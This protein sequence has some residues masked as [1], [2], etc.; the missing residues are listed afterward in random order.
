MPVFI[1]ADSL[2]TNLPT[3]SIK[4]VQIP[5]GSKPDDVMEKEAYM[6][7]NEVMKEREEDEANDT[8]VYVEADSNITVVH[9]PNGSSNTNIGVSPTK[10]CPNIYKKG[11]C[12]PR[13]SY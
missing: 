2:K 5:D 12:P 3:V 10:T 8:P 11:S 6:V 1:E 7:E 13:Q 9:I 4:V